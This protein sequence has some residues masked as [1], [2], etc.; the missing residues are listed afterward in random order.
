MFNGDPTDII[1]MCLNILSRSRG[2]NRWTGP[3]WLHWLAF[4]CGKGSTCAYGLTCW[5]AHDAESALAFYGLALFRQGKHNK[6]FKATQDHI[7]QPS[8]QGW[9]FNGDRPCSN[10]AVD[11][12]GCTEP[13]KCWAKKDKEHLPGSLMKYRAM[14][15]WAID[16]LLAQD[17]PDIASAQMW[18]ALLGLDLAPLAVP[19]V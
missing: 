10:S 18:A 1:E 13:D 15:Q 19:N 14:A 12:D 4:G 6:Q 16:E 11:V 3:C 8:L 5:Q 2:E 17:S 7:R 9:Q